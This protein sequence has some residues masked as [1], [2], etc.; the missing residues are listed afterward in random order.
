VGPH[1]NLAPYAEST[2]VFLAPHYH[3]LDIRRALHWSIG[4]L[5]IGL[6]MDCSR[7]HALAE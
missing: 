7:V 5:A 3:D 4:M 2:N 6:R 1:W